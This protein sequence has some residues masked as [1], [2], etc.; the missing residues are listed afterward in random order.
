MLRAKQIQNFPITSKDI[1]N[2]KV[3]LVPHILGL[4]GKEVRR[5]PKWVG[6]YRVAIP[7]DL[8]LLHR[9]VTLVSDLLFLNGIPFLLRYPGIFVL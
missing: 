2:A 9:S 5:T 6:I 8:Q 1:T 7:R 3:F 4:R